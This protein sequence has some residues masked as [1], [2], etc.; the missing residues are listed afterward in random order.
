MKTS[1]LFFIIRFTRG[2]CQTISGNRFLLFA[3][4]FGGAAVYKLGAVQR[5]LTT[6][7]SVTWPVQANAV[8]VVY[9]RL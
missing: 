6:G 5:E 4:P 9:N 3:V 2:I 8:S 1:S 7:V